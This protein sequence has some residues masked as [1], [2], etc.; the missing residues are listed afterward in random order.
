MLKTLF[1]SLAALLLTA[2]AASPAGAASATSDFLPPDQAF[3]VF[4]RAT[5]ADRIEVAYAVTDG[6]YLYRNKLKFKVADGAPVTLGLPFLPEG[7]TKSDEYFGTQQVYHHDFTVTLP[8]SRAAGAALTLP[9][10]LTWQGCAD[11]GLCYPPITRTFEVALPAADTAV[12]AAPGGDGYVAEQDWLAGLI[13]GGSLW[14][15]AG[16]F[17]LSGLGLAFTPCVL[18]MVPIIAGIIA[19]HGAHVTRLKG[20]TLALTYVLGMAATYTAAGMAFAAA[21]KQ[22]QTL[23]QQPWII[24]LFAALFVAMALSMFG[25]FTLQAP[26]FLQS[27]LSELSNRQRAGSYL[28]VAVMG[29][30]SALIVTTCVGPALVAAL[31]VIGQSGQ[32]LRGGVALFAMALGMGTPLLVVGASAGQLL[33]RAGA[34]METVKQVFGALMLAVAAW[35]ISR[36]LP[37]RWALLLWAVPAAALGVVLLRAAVRA[38]LPLL[39]VRAGGVLAAAYAL[40]LVF[41]AV[42][43]ATDPTAPWA[44][45]HTVVEVPFTTIKSVA[46]LDAAVARASAAGQPVLLDF[47]ADWCVS[48]KEMEKYT[49]PDPAVRAALGN[50]LLLR[51]DVTANDATDQALLQ[52]FGIFGPPTIAFYGADGAERANLRVVG[53]MKA[54]E[55]AAVAQRAVQSAP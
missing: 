16:V 20:F 10:T 44:A 17:F 11:A 7:E 35:M 25:F 55:F 31:S 54:T 4:V 12:A 38:Q 13:R 9:V 8:V 24:T 6:Y 47:Y 46:D 22:A 53:F 40:L 21:G 1:S 50:A 36:L 43:G 29:A 19:G 18:P 32:M 26:A 48:C 27:R 52:R 45:A 39:L 42:R 28:G 33:P 23:F 14:W 51:A 3:K 37:E 49:F 5:A 15:M 2:G 34:W 30:L 41:G